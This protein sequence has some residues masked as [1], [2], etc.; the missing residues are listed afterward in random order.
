MEEN[1]TFGIELAT[2]KQYLYQ[3]NQQHWGQRTSDMQMG[4][5]KKD[6]S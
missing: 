6:E 2:G 5:Q 3:G 1:N 4:V